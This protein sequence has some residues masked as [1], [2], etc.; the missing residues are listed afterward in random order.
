[1]SL[2]PPP[3]L[4]TATFCG[5][6]RSWRTT[7]P[8]PHTFFRSTARATNLSDKTTKRHRI[9]DKRTICSR[10]NRNMRRQLLLTLFTAA[11]LCLSAADR[12]REVQLQQALDL[13][14]TKG[15]LPGAIKLLEEVA[16]SADRNLAA[17]SLLYLGDC[18]QKLGQ[19]EASKPYERVLR[20]FADQREV[21][22][23]AQSRLAALRQPLA[24][25][26]GIITRQVWT[27]P[28]VDIFGTV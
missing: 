26:N 22:S 20:D 15:D 12:P 1:M 17:R 2:H 3:A 5:C 16:K 25:R 21:A 19:Q 7:R 27:G 11:A 23:E 9:R 14:Q 28:N 18:R 8:I 4:L 6:G 10:Q 13:M 24:G